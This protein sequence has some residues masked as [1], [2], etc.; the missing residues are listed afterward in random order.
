MPRY[1]IR[2]RFHPI[3]FM[4]HSP[5]LFPL[6]YLIGVTV[7]LFPFRYRLARFYERQRQSPQTKMKGSAVKYY[8]DIEFKYR[9]ESW[10]RHIM[11][12]NEGDYKAALVADVMNHEIREG[13]VHADSLYW[14]AHQKD[15]QRAGRLAKEIGELRAQGGQ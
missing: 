2:P 10:W 9:R 3:E 14:R 1:P 11:W 7:V 4:S 13:S 8:R 12:S 15:V 5:H 6:Y